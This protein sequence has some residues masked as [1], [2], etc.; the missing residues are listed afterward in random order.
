MYNIFTNTYRTEGISEIILP[1]Y[2]SFSQSPHFLNAP[3]FKPTCHYMVYQSCPPFS[4]EKEHRPGDLLQPRWRGTSRD[5]AECPTQA[6]PYQPAEKQGDV[7][8]KKHVKKRFTT[9]YRFHHFIIK[10]NMRTSGLRLGDR[11]T[12]WEPS[13]TMELMMCVVLTRF[14]SC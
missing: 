5:P 11:P 3:G 2:N 9:W 12:A 14:H 4:S 10:V 1:K 13:G 6:Q 7:G 8:T